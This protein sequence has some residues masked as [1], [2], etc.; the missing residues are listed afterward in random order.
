MYRSSV[1]FAVFTALSLSL[2][3]CNEHG[4]KEV[5]YDGSSD[6]DST[7]ELNVNK[8]VDILFVIDNS[9]SMGDEQANLASNFEP[10]IEALEE[11]NVEANYRIAVT[12]TDNGNP[13]CGGATTPEG[14]AFVLSS[15]QN[16]LEHFVWN[17]SPAVDARDVACLDICAYE[18]DELEITPTASGAD[19]TLKP[20][21]WLEN[22]E[23]QTNLPS[24]ITTTEAFQC[25]GPQGVDGCGFESP[26]E[27]MYKA[28]ARAQNSD[29]ASYGFLRDDALL[30]VVFVTDEVDCSHR[31]EA[32]DIF[33]PDSVFSHDPEYQ[34]ATSSICWNAGVECSGG[35]GEYDEC[36]AVDKNDKGTLTSDPDEAVL[37]PVSRY[38]DFLQQIENAKNSA[39]IDREVIVAVISGVPNGA[40]DIVYADST[41]SEHM[42]DF[43]VGPGCTSDVNGEEQTAQP[44]VRLKKFAD[45]FRNGDAENMFSVCS[46]DYSPALEEVANAIRTQFRPACFERCVEDIDA[47]TQGVQPECYLREVQDEVETAIPECSVLDGEWVLPDADTDICYGIVSDDDGST[48]TTRD[49]M[50][51]E[52][53]D[54][55]WNLEFKIVRREGVAALPDARVEATC[56]L[57]ELPSVTCPD[58]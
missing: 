13:L 37:Q 16:R 33:A 52:C 42:R 22:I 18:N 49:D 36:H 3:A 56:Q 12:T 20:R 38:T 14:G 31:S 57:A 34:A 26:L 51:A 35:P 21:P 28:L 46:E 45:A 39:E 50:S 27:S 48:T 11:K 41:N 4:V 47:A 53:I 43:G 29:E 17:G 40:G 58:S 44:P 54:D 6:D 23:G 30:A 5:E 7:V 15:C 24:G 2:P 25:F 55:G 1:S 32:G 10:F 8:N 9:G 19:A